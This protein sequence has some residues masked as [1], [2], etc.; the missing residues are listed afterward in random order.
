MMNVLATRTRTIKIKLFNKIEEGVKFRK[1]S[2][3]FTRVVYKNNQ[4]ISPASQRI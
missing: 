4:N 2:L 1:T 3:K